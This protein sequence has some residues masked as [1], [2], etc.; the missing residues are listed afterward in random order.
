MAVQ[1]A[2]VRVAKEMDDT[3]LRA[4]ATQQGSSARPKSGRPTSTILRGSRTR[5][6]LVSVLSYP[7]YC[8]LDSFTVGKSLEVATHDVWPAQA[9]A[10][11]LFLRDCLGT[12]D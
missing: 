2:E 7:M 12:W 5:N 3:F 10:R 1:N 9:S 11:Q 6:V 8:R 4:H